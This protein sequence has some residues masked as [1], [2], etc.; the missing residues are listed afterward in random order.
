MLNICSISRIIV[1]QP[2]TSHAC[3]VC[4]SVRVWIEDLLPAWLIV[5]CDG[6]IMTGDSYGPSPVSGG[7]PSPPLMIEGPRR[8]PSAPVGRR[9][10]PYGESCWITSPPSPIFTPVGLHLSTTTPCPSL[11][12]PFLFQLFNPPEFFFPPVCDPVHLLAPFVLNLLSFFQ[13]KHLLFAGCFSVCFYS[14]IWLKE[15]FLNHLSGVLNSSRIVLS[16]Y[17]TVIIISLHPLLFQKPCCLFQFC[18]ISLSRVL[19][20]FSPQGPRPPS[21]PHGRYPDNKHIP[22]MGMSCNISLFFSIR[23]VLVKPY[24]HDWQVQVTQQWLQE[25]ILLSKLFSFRARLNDVAF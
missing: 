20:L 19:V 17:M 3:S 18:Q 10:D 22:G 6:L 7:A 12:A 2:L 1:D 5:N 9:I 11:S 23:I 15:L 14:C 21:D 8:P 25:I 13:F 16:S 4:D 24:R